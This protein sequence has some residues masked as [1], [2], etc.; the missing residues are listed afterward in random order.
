MVKVQELHLSNHLL[1]DRSERLEKI[2]KIGYGQV[3]KEQWYNDKFHCLTDTG[4][5]LV[6]DK[7]KTYCV[8]AYFADYK[9]V[10]KMYNGNVPKQ[11][12]RKIDRNLSFGIAKAKGNRI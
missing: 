3:I 1:Y 4:L 7:N 8:T 2:R 5:M 6:V 12:R 9:E 11:I 10:Q